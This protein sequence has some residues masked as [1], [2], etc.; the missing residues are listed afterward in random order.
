MTGPR[1]AQWHAMIKQL[2]VL[3]LQV[4]TTLVVTVVDWVL[5]EFIRLYHNVPADTASK[6]VDGNRQACCPSRAG[7][8]WLPEGAQS[9]RRSERPLLGLPWYGQHF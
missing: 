8:W 5:A 1:V 6:V 9:A 7:F 3:L 4:I 2:Q